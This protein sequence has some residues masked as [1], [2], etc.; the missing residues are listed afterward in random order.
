MRGE[1][2][3]KRIALRVVRR[4]CSRVATVLRA[5]RAGRAK[6]RVSRVSSAVHHRSPPARFVGTSESGNS[7]TCVSKPSPANHSPSHPLRITTLTRPDPLTVYPS[8]PGDSWDVPRRWTTLHTNCTMS[9]SSTTP[10]WQPPGSH[11][12][13]TNRFAGA[14]RVGWNAWREVVVGVMTDTCTPTAHRAPLLPQPL[15]H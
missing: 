15:S 12:G 4:W 5:L 8:Q 2:R 10:S 1:S 9:G 6:K 11:H 3:S 13:P 7:G 14:Y